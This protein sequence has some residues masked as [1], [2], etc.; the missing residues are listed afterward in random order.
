MAAEVNDAS[1]PTP[2]ASASFDAGREPDPPK[3]RFAA[4]EP[5]YTEASCDELADVTDIAAAYRPGA[6]R[7]TAEALAKRRY[8]T[9]L[10]F[11]TV[12]D[13]A[14]LGAWFQRTETFAGVVS[15]FDAAVHEGSHIWG[16]KHFNLRTVSYPVRADLTIETKRLTNFNRGEILGAIGEDA[17]DSY[18]KTYLAGPN[19]AQGFNTL[20]DEYNAYTHS[21]ATRVCTRDLLGNTRVSA[22]DGILAMM[23]Y[24]EVYLRLAR[25]QHP[26]D[27]A[28]ILTDPGHRRLILTVWN[29]A[30]LWL[31]KSAPFPALGID[32]A[33]LE[34]RAYAADGLAEITHVRDAEHR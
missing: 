23:F 19:G 4:G 33:R 27:Y 1:T 22:R 15:H 16:A 8:P 34:S 12:Q 25:E 21:L 17:N 6:T 26:A 3:P 20:L 28:A 7:A 30:E 24:V 10:P 2:V 32:D 5:G 13:D 9:G 31:R 11:L 18:A 29:R 14:M